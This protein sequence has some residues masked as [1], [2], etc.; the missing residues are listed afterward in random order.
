MAGDNR[1]VSAEKEW[2]KTFKVAIIEEDED[3]LVQMVESMPLFAD[4]EDMQTVLALI[5]EATKRFESEKRSLAKEMLK[6]KEAKKFLIST[7]KESEIH[8]RLDIH[9]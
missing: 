2:I 9:S 6:V 1:K 7:K 4:I 8:R 3:L 5:Q